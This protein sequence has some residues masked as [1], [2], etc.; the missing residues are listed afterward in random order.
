MGG[1]TR[2]IDNLTEWS[3][4]PLSDSRDL[5]GARQASQNRL[6]AVI[7]IAHALGACDFAL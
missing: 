5:F 3:Q 4:N 7:A 6:V 1:G 2:G